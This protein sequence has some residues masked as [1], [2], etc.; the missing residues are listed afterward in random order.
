MGYHENGVQNRFIE[1]ST[2][3]P[4]GLSQRFSGQEMSAGSKIFGNDFTVS[5]FLIFSQKITIRQVF[6]SYLA[7]R[8][9]HHFLV[10][11]ASAMLSFS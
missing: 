11:T 9:V 10:V 3:P 7:N 6:L 5:G 1:N 8:N 2:R 4:G